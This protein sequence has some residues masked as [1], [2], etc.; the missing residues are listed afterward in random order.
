MF[1][2]NDRVR[3][4]D[5]TPWYAACQGGASYIHI[6]EQ[7]FSPLFVKFR[8]LEK[9]QLF[10]DPAD[11]EIELLGGRTRQGFAGWYAESDQAV[12]HREEQSS[13]IWS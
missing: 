6:P 13:I 10:A 8:E 11:G 9:M 12:W 4:L 2:S 7:R 3:P 1:L 5:L